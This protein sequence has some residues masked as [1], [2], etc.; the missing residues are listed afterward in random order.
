MSLAVED[1]A[2]LIPADQQ[3]SNTSPFA[4]RWNRASGGQFT[5]ESYMTTHPDRSPLFIAAFA[6]AAALSVAGCNRTPDPTST[7]S[8]GTP[9][10]DQAPAPARS[11]GTT[12]DDTGITTRVKAAFVADPDIKSLDITVETRKGEVQL[13]GFVDSQRQ[14]D[15]ATDIARRVDGVVGVQNMLALKTPGT[16]GSA[17]DDTLITTKVKTALVRDDSIKSLDIAVNTNKGTVQLSGFVENDAQSARATELA[18]AVD[19]VKAVD[20]KMS[21]KK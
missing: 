11:V 6:L 21:V 12:I 18:R 13:S 15:R 3:D 16:V 4:S 20:N 7:P 17:V 1:A 9:A 2:H 5:K 14:I 8:A 19:G 10:L